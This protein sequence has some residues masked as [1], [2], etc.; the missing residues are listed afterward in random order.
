MNDPLI[1]RNLKIDGNIARATLG[2]DGAQ[3]QI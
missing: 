1:Y 3:L 2:T